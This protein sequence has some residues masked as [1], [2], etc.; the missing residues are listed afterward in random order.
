MMARLSING[1]SRIAAAA[2]RGSQ[3]TGM[4]ARLRV[5]LLAD[6]P[7]GN[8]RDH[9]P[10]QAPRPP[11]EHIARANPKQSNP[12]ARYRRKSSSTDPPTEWGELVQ[13]HDDRHIF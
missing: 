4:L 8:R 9:L 10:Q 7:D 6:I 5:P 13:V 3:D 2:T 12:Q 11:L 1:S